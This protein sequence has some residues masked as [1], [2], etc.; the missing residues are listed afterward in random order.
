[1]R[2]LRHVFLA[3]LAVALL[4]ASIFVEASVA[5]MRQPLVTDD[6]PSA[7][8]AARPMVADAR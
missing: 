5:P 1:M 2:E 3:L 6:A 7:S 4:A 8:T